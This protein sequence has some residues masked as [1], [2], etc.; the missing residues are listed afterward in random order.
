[1]SLM[2]RIILIAFLAIPV[3]TYGQDVL[4]ELHAKPFSISGYDIERERWFDSLNNSGRTGN[5]NG[6]SNRTNLGLTISIGNKKNLFYVMDVNWKH[7][8]YRDNYESIY[9]NPNIFN[10]STPFLGAERI[11]LGLGVDRRISLHDRVLSFVGIRVLYAHQFNY[12]YEWNSLNTDS[13]GVTLLTQTDDRWYPNENTFGFEAVGRLYFKILPRFSI[14]MNLINRFGITFISGTT[15]QERITLDADG[16]E[17][18]YIKQELSGT[19]TRFAYNFSV[20]FGI[21][22]QLAKRKEKK[23]KADPK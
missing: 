18:Y 9:E 8:S 15:G 7:E 20:S 2:A 11:E 5:E 21:Q 13:L 4:V 14:G 16:I 19:E 22:Y 3:L 1:M 12:K 10:T 6:V 17:T 23:K